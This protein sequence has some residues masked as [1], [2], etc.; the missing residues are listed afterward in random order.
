MF[1]S[2]SGIKG[3]KGDQGPQGERGPQGIQG[4]AGEKGA[5][6]APG[7]DGRDGID[8]VQG[9]QGDTGAQGPKGDAFTYADFTAEQLEALRG[10]AGAQGPQGPKGNAFKYTDFTQEQLN[11]L[12]GPKGDKGEAGLP[13]GFGIPTAT[14]DDAYGTPSVTITTSGTNAEKV[15]NFEFKNLKGKPGIDGQNASEIKFYQITQEVSASDALKG[16]D[17]LVF[18]CIVPAAYDISAITGDGTGSN[19]ND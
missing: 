15:F 11:S 7:K 9:P 3:E 14:I 5:D 8:G 18:N 13:A 10:P 17:N 6:G 4:P 12:K 16:E 19:I 2:F 1:F